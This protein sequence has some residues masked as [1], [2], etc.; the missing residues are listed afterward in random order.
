[1]KQSLLLAVSV[2]LTVIAITIQTARME[3]IKDLLLLFQQ[4]FTVLHNVT[5][6][7][8]GKQAL[9]QHHLCVLITRVKKGTILLQVF[10]GRNV[11]Q[12]SMI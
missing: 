7:V 8:L 5:R 3:F 1:M 9:Q 4:I 12:M 10:V 11:L 2:T 6:L